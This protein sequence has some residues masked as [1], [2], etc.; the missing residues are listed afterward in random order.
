MVTNGHGR[1]SKKMLKKIWKSEKFF[2]DSEY[3]NKLL[4]TIPHEKETNKEHA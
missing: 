2:I 3:P 4:K 1:K